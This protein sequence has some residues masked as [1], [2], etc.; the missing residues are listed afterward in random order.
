MAGDAEGVLCDLVQLRGK[1]PAI[2]E[3]AKE[4][5]LHLAPQCRALAGLHLWG[6]RNTTADRLSRIQEDG[7]SRHLDW[8]LCNATERKVPKVADMK[9]SYSSS[10]KHES[11]FLI[12]LSP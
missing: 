3:V 1:A 9:F 7:W 4:V 6:G 5:A 2:N 11:A 12:Q 10:K 8:A